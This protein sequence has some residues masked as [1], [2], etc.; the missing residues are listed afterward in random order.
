MIG[1]FK[2]QEMR[3]RVFLGLLFLF[4]I[5]A[6]FL[7]LRNRGTVSTIL[8]GALISFI[9]IVSL[10]YSVMK[11]AYPGTGNREVLLWL[12]ALGVAGVF[13]SLMVPFISGFLSAYGPVSPPGSTGSLSMYEDPV[14]GFRISYPSTW[15]QF[16]RKNPNSDLVTNTAF[17]SR[18]GK[19]AATVQVTDLS[20]P[21]YLGLP[22]DVWTNHTIEILSSNKISSQFTL[23]RN[24]R[25]V[26]AGYPAQNLEYTIVLNSGDKIRTVGYLL[27]AGSKGYNI[28]FTSREDTFNDWSGTEQEMFNSFQITG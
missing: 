28:G 1:M 15:N 16:K 19:T 23:L 27:E 2:D 7:Y 11:K 18:D 4:A 26:L 17:I 6:V 22:L 9:V 20:G 12:I 13:I 8:L 10:L 3:E 21:G 25:T 14:L 5:L 24:E